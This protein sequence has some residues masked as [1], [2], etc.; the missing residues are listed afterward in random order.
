MFV[1]G[2]CARTTAAPPDGCPREP[3]ANV[4]SSQMPSDVCIPPN[5]TD[6]ATDYFDDY[7][8]RAFLSLVW[9]ADANQRGDADASRS[10]SDSGPRAF[11][12][13]K[14][15][16]EVFHRDGSAPTGFG[17]YD[18]GTQNA[19]G[20][21]GAFG[22]VIIGSFSA[23]EDVAQ[24]GTGEMLPP[25]AGRN[26]RYVRT[27]TL[28]NRVAY[29]YIVAKKLYLRSSLPPIPS[30]KPSEPVLQFPNGSI[31]LKAAWLDLEGFSEAEKSRYYARP[32]TL[33]DVNSGKCSVVTMGLVGLHIVQKT[34]SR[35]QWIWSTFEQVDL[36]PPARAGAPGTFALHT[37]SAD[38]A[39]AEN[40]L[41]L[42][43]LPKEPVK[44]FNVNRASVS[45]IHPKT[46]YTNLMY[47]RKLKGTVWQNY[48]LVMTQWPRVPG[49]QSI[50]VPASLNG[51]ASHTFPGLGTASG[52]AF[53]NVTMETFD[54]ERPQLG[55]MNCHNQARLA[56]D[57]MWSV[58]DHAYPPALVPK[59]K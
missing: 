24:F 28:Y 8:W 18:S 41:T 49:E 56:A 13:Y 20:A 45:P 47:E 12:T 46:A 48:Q 5:F 19:C 34:A 55:C 7:S 32:V 25:V 17:A 39:P 31:V 27:Q 38:P 43:P 50:P 9:P 58:L 22:K 51:D 42:V 1:L 3:V 44:A 16:W 23:M 21:A 11:E 14:A 53:A 52:S 35:P 29:D 2:V 40:P 59:A 15:L 26:G 37:G 54:Q 33:R 57:F 6:V 30:P 36:V 10:L 4:S